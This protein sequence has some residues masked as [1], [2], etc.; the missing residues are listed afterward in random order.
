MRA[1]AKA[2][3]ARQGRKM[4][5]K[6]I[7]KVRLANLNKLVEERFNGNASLAA[8]A[9]ER[10]HTFVW[11]L[12]NRRRAIGEATARHIERMIGLPLESLDNGMDSLG[13][14][15]EINVVLPGGERQTYYMVPGVR[16][17]AELEERTGEYRPCGTPCSGGT[18]WAPVTT[19][20][21]KP[22]LTKGEEA[23]IDTERRVLVDEGVFVVRAKG[24][25]SEFR[26]ARARSGGGFRLVV[27]DKSEPD[28]DSCDVEVLGQVIWR[29]SKV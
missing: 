14:P 27:L 26:V 28:L 13:R 2:V 11:Q 24:R 17:V 15:R 6:D 5:R 12:V 7:H 21:V 4:S 3:L 23:F 1:S 9:I 16:S 22:R 10:S 8:K 18:V 20:A 29:G 19:N 25:E